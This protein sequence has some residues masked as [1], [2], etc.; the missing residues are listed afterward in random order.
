MTILASL[1]LWAVCLSCHA[2]LQPVRYGLP[3]I[4]RHWRNIMQ[5][6]RPIASIMAL[7]TTLLRDGAVIGMVEWCMTF[8]VAGVIV[9]VGVAGL[10]RGRP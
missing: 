6:I 7:A 4:P 8:S 1:L 2:G 5:A 10:R 9:A 3:H